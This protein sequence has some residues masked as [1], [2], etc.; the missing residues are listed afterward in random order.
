M[1][2]WRGRLE[3]AAAKLPAFSCNSFGAQRNDFDSM[4]WLRNIA[5]RSEFNFLIFFIA[6]RPH[7]L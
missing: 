4:A 3:V 1:P 6:T 5:T 7:F 2:F